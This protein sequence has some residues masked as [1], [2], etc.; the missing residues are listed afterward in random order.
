[1]PLAETPAFLLPTKDKHMPMP[2]FAF[3][4]ETVLDYGGF[5]RANG[6][7]SDDEARKIL[8]DEFAKPPFHKVVAIAAIRAEYSPDRMWSVRDVTARHIGEMSEAELIADFLRMIDQTMPILVSYNGLGFDL[9]VLQWRSLLYGLPGL[10]L[11]RYAGK[12]FSR[13]AE[14]HIDLCAEL[15]G[16]SARGQVR[17]DEACKLF[18]VA[19]KTAGVDGS[20]VSSL[21]DCGRWDEIAEYCADDVAATL[22]LFYLRET[23]KNRLD[24]ERLRL[25]LKDLEGAMANWRERRKPAVRHGAGDR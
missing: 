10:H 11:A 15:S 14:H 20:K 22:R 4:I 19:G 16:A 9:P 25:S 3:D 21:A 17:L 8:G 13:F 5:A 12:Y 7:S 2:V 23:F 24:A 1:V 6:L 18:G